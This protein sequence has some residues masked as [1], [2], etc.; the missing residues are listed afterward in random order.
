M[1]QNCNVKIK[2]PEDCKFIINKLESA[3]YEAYI[4]GGCVRDFLLGKTPQD[5]DITTSALP[6]QVK[7]LFS[8]TVDTGIAHGTVMVVRHG[9]GY[10]ITTY[11]VDG[12]YKDGRHPEAVTFTRS[13]EEDLKRRDFTIN[14]FAY[15]DTKG[16]VDLFGGMD[17][18]NN[19][20]I[21]AVG[22]PYERFNEDALRIMRAIRFAAQLGFEVERETLKAI[23]SFS[24]NL[25]KVSMERIRVEFEKTL[26]SDNPEMVE[27][28]FK[29]GMGKYIVPGFENKCAGFDSGLAKKMDK[30]RYLLLACFL[31]HLSYEESR[32]VISEMKYDNKTKEAVSKIVLHMDENW[33]W[34]DTDNTKISVKKLLS[35][36]GEEEFFLV[37]RYKHEAAAQAAKKD[38]E[39][40]SQ[41]AEEIIMA[42]EAYTISQLDIT[43]NDLIEAGV[44]EGSFVGEKL[45]FLLDRVIEDPSLNEK[46][47]LLKLL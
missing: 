18:L 17:D 12:E 26:L 2:V 40:I 28:F 15:N 10:E 31:R 39:K 45:R 22:N 37:C 34:K 42:G 7:S 32:K 13:L 25:A 5:W 20:I 14:A 3:G 24:D 27:I 35:E 33:Q 46:D 47:K 4:V 6:E 44:K 43:G 41:I 8:N 16:L 11:R 21:K 19:K 9:E 23:E 29:L 36:L 38:Y 30:N 1:N